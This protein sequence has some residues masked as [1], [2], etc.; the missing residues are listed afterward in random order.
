MAARLNHFRVWLALLFVFAGFHG[1]C[2]TNS[3]WSAR[4]WQ[5]DDGLLDNEINGITQGPDGYLWIVTPWV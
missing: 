2:S 1:L 5:I 3:R 4:V